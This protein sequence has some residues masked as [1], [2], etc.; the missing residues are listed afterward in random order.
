M[1][2][3]VIPKPLFSNNLYNK[4]ESLGARSPTNSISSRVSSPLPTSRSTSPAGFLPSPIDPPFVPVKLQVPSPTLIVSVPR[5]K[6]AD[7]TLQLETL[8]AT[9][10]PV[11][12]VKMKVK[13][14]QFK[15]LQNGIENSTESVKELNWAYRREHMSDEPI[16][17]AEKQSYISETHRILFCNNLE[18]NAER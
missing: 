14:R 15:G 1:S 17:S 16:D 4:P 9:L 11:R 2:N 8:P 5:S 13:I 18:E 10:K 12:K 3:G 7:Q 6:L